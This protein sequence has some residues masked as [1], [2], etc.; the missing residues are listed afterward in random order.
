MTETLEPDPGNAGGGKSVRSCADVF[1]TQ[2][3]R[4]SYIARFFN[5]KIGYVGFNKACK[6]MRTGAYK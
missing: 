6:W 3:V 4:Y 5:L 2:S 1:W